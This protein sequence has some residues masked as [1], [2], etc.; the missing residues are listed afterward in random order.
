MRAQIA[1]VA[2]ATSLLCAPT[3]F[4]DA[5]APP[6]LSGNGS[7]SVTVTPDVAS[8][9]VGV[10]RSAPTSSAALSAANR[11]VDAIVSAVRAVGV[12]T[13]GIE[14]NLVDV[15]RRTVRIGAR[16]HRRSVRRFIATESLSITTTAALAGQV[17]DVTVR[18]RADSV[19][20]P[21]FSF[22]DPSAGMVAATNA[23]LAD[24]RRRAA[25]AAASL[26]YAVTGVQSVNLDPQSEVLAPGS[27][28]APAPVAARPPT[29][30]TVHPGA[31][32]VDATV[33]VVFTIA[34]A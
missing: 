21:S 9:T 6:S 28:S 7:G 22:S 3:A 34:P 11:R 15:S 20:G 19:N 30:T 33:T 2:V 25:A 10:T 12:P 1:L 5:T 8:L 27:A 14:T 17:I 24:A 4:A 26:G 16:K 18:A 31:Q 32:E 13:S 29:P 23:A